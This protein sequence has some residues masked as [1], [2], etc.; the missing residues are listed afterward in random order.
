MTRVFR[1]V[2]WS[3]VDA[4]LKAGWFFSADLGPTH[5]S[6]SVLM[7]LVCSCTGGGE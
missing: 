1:Y 4:Y 6:Y 2:P 7:E 3:L 5:G